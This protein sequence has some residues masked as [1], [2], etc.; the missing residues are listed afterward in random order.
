MYN[1]MRWT[2]T[3]VSE[4]HITYVFRVEDV[5]CKKIDIVTCYLHHYAIPDTLGHGYQTVGFHHWILKNYLKYT[6]LTWQV[7]DFMLMLLENIAATGET[8]CF[9]H[10]TEIFYSL[11]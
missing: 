4:E 11:V 6:S 1:V 10:F 2:P 8:S 5:K 9:R 7:N 3:G